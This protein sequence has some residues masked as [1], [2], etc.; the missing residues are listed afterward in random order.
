MAGTP[1]GAGNLISSPYAGAKF[2]NGLASIDSNSRVG[3]RD[4]SRGIKTS[5][6]VLYGKEL[7]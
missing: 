1:G 4:Q 7:D 6:E 2:S 5:M 3:H